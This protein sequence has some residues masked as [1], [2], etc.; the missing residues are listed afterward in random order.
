L[1]LIPFA[2][3][4]DVIS[5]PLQ[6]VALAIWGDDYLLPFERPKPPPLTGPDE[7]FWLGLAPESRSSLQ[8]ILIE[9]TVRGEQGKEA[10]FGLTADGKWVEIEVG[11]EQ[12]QQ[13]L[14]RSQNRR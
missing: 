6:L 1:V 5:F 8:A 4:A 9:R 11:S 2:F 10:V 14:A 13:L 12:S 7:S 3:A